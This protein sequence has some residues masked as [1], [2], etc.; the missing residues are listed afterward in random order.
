MTQSVT[1]GIPTETVG[2]R[3]TNTLTGHYTTKLLW[4]TNLTDK[5]DKNGCF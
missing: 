4:N 2:T 1:A 5:I 3:L